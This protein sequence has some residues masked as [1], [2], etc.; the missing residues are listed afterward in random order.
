M[1]RREFITLLGGTAAAWPLAARAQ[2]PERMRRIGYLAS[3]SPA[4]VPE[5]MSAFREGLRER[6]YIEGQNLRFEYRW[7]TELNETLAAELIVLNVDVIVAWATPAVTA[8]RRATSKIP[9]VMVG[10]ADPIGAGFVANLSRPGGN[11]TGTTNLARDL[12]GKLLELLL[13]IAP[14]INPVFVLRNPDNPASPLQLREVEVAARSLDLRVT[15][16][17]AT[18]PREVDAAFARMIGENAK[19]VIALADPLLISQRAQLADLAQKA[20]LPVI[21]SRRENV[22]AGGLISYGPSLRGQFRDTAMYVDKILKGADP[23]NLPVEQPTR[24]ELVVNLKTAKSL[25]LD[26]P[27][28]LLARADEVIE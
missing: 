1:K 25:G 17:E 24:L 3:L 23:A 28:T 2:Q 6:G 15:L 10:I 16:V 13:E 19:G 14:R 5:L 20:R 18:S 8:A 11:I 26:V 22:E 12:G 9:I 7:A 27:P 21:F 4:M